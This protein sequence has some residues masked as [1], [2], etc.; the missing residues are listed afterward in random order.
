MPDSAMRRL[1]SGDLAG[2]INELKSKAANGDVSAMFY[3]GRTY[4]EV[5]GI[6]HD[7][8][9]AMKWYRLAAEK[10]SGP[11][12]WS[13]GRLFEM[14]KGVDTDLLEAQRCYRQALK[15][16]FR[17][18]SLTKIFVRWFPGPQPL[19]LDAAPSSLGSTVP[20]T[21]E[22][23][24]LRSAGLRGRLTVQGSQLGHFGLSARVLIVAQ[25]RLDQEVTLEIPEEGT[26]IYLQRDSSW[27][28]LPAG[29]P[30][31]KRLLRLG[32]QPENPDFTIVMEELEG[33]G[34]QG[35]GAFSWTRP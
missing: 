30:T 35:G 34:E 5:K 20:N 17:R 12:S 13:I 9:E 21:E 7:Y 33:G 23:I 8:V 10:G 2:C 31:G 14:G 1:S 22:L 3:L 18:T 29:T 4:E 15:L 11:A 26:V 6:P 16:G 25:R 24:L 19:L 32:P 28:K 27:E